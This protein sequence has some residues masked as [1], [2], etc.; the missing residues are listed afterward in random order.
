M[1]LASF[2][3]ATSL[4]AALFAGA[5]NATTVVVNPLEESKSMTF[6]GT[7][8]LTELYSLNYYTSFDVSYS[9]TTTAANAG[10]FTYSIYDAD[11]NAV[12][13]SGTLSVLLPGKTTIL[14]M[15]ESFYHDESFY[16]TLTGT[17][18]SSGQ[19]GWTIISPSEE[20]PPVPLPASALMLVGGLGALAVARRK[21]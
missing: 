5:A 19:G 16:V 13:A 17:G 7:S 14:G 2:A 11:D 8:T 12:I 1:K 15:T 6:S 4:A 3:A 21:A 18:V 20:L 9:V 10:K